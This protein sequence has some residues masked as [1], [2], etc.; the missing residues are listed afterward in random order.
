MIE[1]DSFL[2]ESLDIDWIRDR[3][4]IRCYDE[5]NKEVATLD[6]STGLRWNM[7]EEEQGYRFSIDETTLPKGKWIFDGVY[8]T[9]KWLDGNRTSS[10]VHLEGYAHEDGL[11][12]QK[13]EEQLLQ[14]LDSPWDYEGAFVIFVTYPTWKERLSICRNCINYDHIKGTCEIDN[15]FMATKSI[16]AAEECP[17]NKWGISENF[18]AKLAAEK[19]ST[20]Y[21]M[22]SP[23]LVDQKEFEYEWEARNV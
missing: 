8:L 4:I 23:M 6:G 3:T 17:E 15:S 5:N 11:D 13:N 21:T 1:D 7:T 9:N 16:N 2:V 10:Y 19:M 20:A 14:R 12:F 22:I 18:D